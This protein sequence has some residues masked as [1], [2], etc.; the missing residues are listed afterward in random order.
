MKLRTK[1]AVGLVALT[2][3]LSLATYGGKEIYKDSNEKNRIVGLPHFG[4]APISGG[5]THPPYVMSTGLDA[6]ISD[7]AYCP[8][9]ISFSCSSDGP[10][11]DCSF[12]P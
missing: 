2:L 10:R 5:P 1:L 12:P 8:P 9:C 7:P 11:W 4:M 6:K 3:V